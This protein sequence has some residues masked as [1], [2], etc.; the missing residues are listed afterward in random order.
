MTKITVLLTTLAAALMAS[1]PALAH[2]EFKCDVPQAEWRKQMDLQRKLL[3]D[4][5]KKVRQVKVDNGCYEVYGFDETGKRAEVYFNPK[6][7]EKV[8]AVKQPD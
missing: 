2:G 6:T 3:D 1:G 8:G 4:G 5:W 7:F